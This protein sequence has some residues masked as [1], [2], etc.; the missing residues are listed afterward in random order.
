MTETVY[1]DKEIRFDIDV[2]CDKCKNNLSA[3]WK[4]RRQVLY[5]EP[6]DKCIKDSKE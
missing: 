2:D 6:C 4:N 5:V 3:N 1:F